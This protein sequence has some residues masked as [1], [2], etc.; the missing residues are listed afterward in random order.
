MTIKLVLLLALSG[1]A[2]A[3]LWSL[4]RRSLYFPDRILIANPSVFRLPYEDFEVK[5][6]DDLKIHGWWIPA[7]AAQKTTA[8]KPAMPPIRYLAD[9]PTLLVS[10]WDAGN[11][12]HRLEK[13]MVLPKTGAHLGVY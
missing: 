13:A 1:A 9:P 8:G 2:I 5:T 4:E 11:S 3:G 6:G 7:F 10:H 12:S